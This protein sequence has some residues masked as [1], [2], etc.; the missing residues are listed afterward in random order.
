MKTV[1]TVKPYNALQY[2]TWGKAGQE[3]YYQSMEL[4]SY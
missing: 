4:R 1:N 2:N 3:D